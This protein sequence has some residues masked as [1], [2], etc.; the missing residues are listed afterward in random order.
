MKPLKRGIAWLTAVCLCLCGLTAFLALYTPQA[1]TGADPGA[2]E[3]FAQVPL[4]ELAA[5]MVQNQHASF[6]VMQTP[7]GP[8]MLSQL[9]AEYDDTQLYALL[10][11]ATHLSGSRKNTDR[12]TFADYG[13]DSPRATVTLMLA[14]GSERKVQVLM[15]NP[16]DQNVYMYDVEGEAIYLVAGVTAELFLRDEP[17]FMSH[18]PLP[19]R[20]MSDFA[21]IRSLGMQFSGSTRDYTLTCTD[22]GYYLSAPIRQRVPSTVVASQ[23]FVPLLSVYSDAFVAF[24]ANLSDYGF[25]DSFLRL[26][27]TTDAG[28]TQLWFARAQDGGC[29]MARP[30]TGN[31]YTVD[32]SV[33]EA[34]TFDYTLLTG[35][36]AL[37]YGAGDLSQVVFDLPDAQI[38]AEV[39]GTGDTLGVS[40]NGKALGKQEAQTFMNALNGLPIAAE[41]TPQG[42]LPAASLTVTV[43]MRTGAVEVTSFAPAGNGFSYLTVLGDT[44]F[45]VEDQSLQSLIDA[46]R[47]LTG[48]N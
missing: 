48:R 46:L 14:D 11:A 34:L 43:T 26:S 41:A 6:A 31:V 38:V 45:A 7:N 9:T 21:A 10:Y 8:E 33:P 23:L 28:T 15:T 36:T 12:S 4:T 19:L 17:E 27:L 13:I 24:G 16:I 29:L 44:H 1:Q 37:Y 20:D 42:P 3:S 2:V 47:E 18:S 25:D 40:L 32:P 22:T 39:T 30:D 35:G 5:V